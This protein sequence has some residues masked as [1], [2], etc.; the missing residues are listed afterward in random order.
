MKRLK[1]CLKQSVEV[2][3]VHVVEE[4]DGE[5]VG[6]RG[7]QHLPEVGTADGQDEPVCIEQGL[8]AADC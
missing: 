2:S 4:D 5:L 7:R 6:R 3:G 1:T 8:A